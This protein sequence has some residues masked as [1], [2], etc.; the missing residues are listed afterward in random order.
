M[1]WNHNRHG[2]RSTARHEIF[3]QDRGLIKPD[4]E[5]TTA[6]WFS[7]R[8]GCGDFSAEIIEPLREERS[9]ID[10]WSSVKTWSNQAANGNFSQRRAQEVPGLSDF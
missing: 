2:L 1:R 10:R 5:P 3:I 8:N 4:A 6:E 7:V 9:L